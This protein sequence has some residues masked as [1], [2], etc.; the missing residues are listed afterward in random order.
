MLGW[1][2]LVSTDKFRYLLHIND[3]NI[4][5]KRNNL[6]IP[7]CHFNGTWYSLGRLICKDC[8]D[9]YENNDKRHTHENPH[10]SNPC[11]AGHFKNTYG[12]VSL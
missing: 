12:H 11:H 5:Y 8:Q 6:N 4:L 10:I 3:S 9:Y 2:F 1:L 7:E